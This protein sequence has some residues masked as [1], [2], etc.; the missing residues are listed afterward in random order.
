MTANQ[1][2]QRRKRGIVLVFVIV[3]ATDYSCIP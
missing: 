2:E 1:G 3:V